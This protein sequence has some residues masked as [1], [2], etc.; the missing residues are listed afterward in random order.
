MAAKKH[1]LTSFNQRRTLD[2]SLE[3]HAKL[4]PSPR[5]H[6]MEISMA[7]ATMVVLLDG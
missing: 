3:D 5:V 1:C 4:A 7:K 6:G 2:L